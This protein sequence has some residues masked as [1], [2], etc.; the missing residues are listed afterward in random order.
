MKYEN[1]EEYK[2]AGKES[3]PKHTIS[4]HVNTIVHFILFWHLSDGRPH[5]RDLSLERKY[6]KFSFE[7]V[8][9]MPIRHARDIEYHRYMDMLV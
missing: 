7:P 9:K 5:N 8:N 3:T 4:V 2:K 6:P 1:S